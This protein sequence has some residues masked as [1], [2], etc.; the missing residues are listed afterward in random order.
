MDVSRW[1][2]QAWIVARL[3]AKRRAGRLSINAVV[4]AVNDAGHLY[5]LTLTFY[6]VLSA[7][8]EF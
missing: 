3:N 6:K 7:N 5:L 8:Y 1:S 4:G 2:V